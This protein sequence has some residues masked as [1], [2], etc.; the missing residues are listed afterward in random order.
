[1]QQ[2]LLQLNLCLP[3]LYS[4]ALCCC[5][6]QRILFPTLKFDFFTPFLSGVHVN[7]GNS[8]AAF[9]QIKQEIAINISG[10]DHE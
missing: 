5:A 10:Q 8:K 2:P 3:L 1:V 4:S 6:S 9:A 7:L